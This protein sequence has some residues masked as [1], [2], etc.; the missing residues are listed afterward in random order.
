[1]DKLVIKLE[2]EMDK[3]IRKVFNPKEASNLPGHT[4]YVKD[5]GQLSNILSS[6]RLLLLLDLKNSQ[7]VSEVAKKTGRKQEAISRDATILEN[8]GLIKKTKKGRQTFLKTKV[9]KIEI[10]LS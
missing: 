8:A 3:D 1:M 5:A 7:N 2:S 4:L 10:D 6:G 9:K